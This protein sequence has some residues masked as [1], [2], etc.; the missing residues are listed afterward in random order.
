MAATRFCDSSL[1]SA[2]VSLSCSRREGSSFQR[3]SI[4]DGSLSETRA[5]SPAPI[6]RP[7]PRLV[8]EV[9]DVDRVRRATRDRDREH[10]VV[11]AVPVPHQH[12]SAPVGAR[13]FGAQGRLARREQDDSPL[14]ARRRRRTG[15]T[16]ERLLPV[17]GTAVVLLERSGLRL[18]DSVADILGGPIWPART[19]SSRREQRVLSLLLRADRVRE[20]RIVQGSA[21]L[22]ARDLVPAHLEVRRI[23]TIDRHRQLH[24]GNHPVFAI[25]LE[26]PRHVDRIG[27]RRDEDAQRPQAALADLDPVVERVVGLDDERDHPLPDCLSSTLSQQAVSRDD[28]RLGRA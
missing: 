3:T 4:S 9:R 19:H 10:D 16:V 27:L 18:D 21:V 1:A 6:A 14:L 24:A 20:G 7:L 15:S 13:V 11:L 22:H 5:G 8:V 23:G 2:I 17:I 26:V 28:A 12:P 25:E